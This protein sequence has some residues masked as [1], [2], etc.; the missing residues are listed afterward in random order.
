MEVLVKRYK[1]SVV[2]E[3]YVLKI[4]YR[5]AQSLQLTTLCYTLKILLRV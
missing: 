2:Q 4:Y 3:E 5:I 1:V